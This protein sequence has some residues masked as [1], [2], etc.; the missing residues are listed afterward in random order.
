MSQTRA[1]HPSPRAGR[2]A[3]AAVTV[4]GGP[5][6]RPRSCPRAAAVGPTPTPHNPSPPDRI[7]VAPIRVALSASRYP[8]PAS[9]APPERTLA[10]LRALRRPLRDE[11]CATREATHVPSPR[12][13]PPRGAVAAQPACHLVLRCAAPPSARSRSPRNRPSRSSPLSA[14]RAAPPASTSAS[15]CRDAPPRAGEGAEGGQGGRVSSRRRR[16]L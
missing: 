3:G 7:R 12:S 2:G 10:R 16:P 14:S 13:P 8:R 4:T 15:S 9:T 6:P 5:T 11:R 1:P